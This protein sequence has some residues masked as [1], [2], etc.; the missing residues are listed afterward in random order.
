[1]AGE[2]HNLTKRVQFLEDKLSETQNLTQEIENMEAQFKLQLHEQ[3]NANIASSLRIHGV[4][5]VEGEKLKHVF[6]N[7]CLRLNRTPAPAIKEIS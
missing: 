1:M 7:L 6:N 5:Y 4:P 2:I 3:A